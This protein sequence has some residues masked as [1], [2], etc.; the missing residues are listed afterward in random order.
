VS[1]SG[2]EWSEGLRN[3][4]SVIIRRYTHHTQFYCFFHIPLVLLCI[5]V[6]MVVCFVW[7]CL[8][9]YNMYSYCYV[10]FIVMY[11]YCYVLL[12][13]CYVFLLLCMF[14]VF[15][16]IVLFCVLFVC[17]CVLYCCHRVS[18]QLQL[19]KICIIYISWRVKTAVAY[20]WQPYHLHVPTIL[21]SGSL[22]LLEPSRNVQ[23]CNGKALPSL[24]WR[25]IS[26]QRSN[27][28]FHILS[29]FISP[30]CQ[31][32]Y[33]TGRSMATSHQ[34]PCKKKQFCNYGSREVQTHF[35]ALRCSKSCNL[36]FKLFCFLNIENLD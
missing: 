34:L 13:L 4:V 27:S 22:N 32:S 5:T 9:L 6:Y 19:K 23:A 7:F 18:T 14:C 30:V 31:S 29:Q 26:K 20:G 3:R 21:K 10:F 36:R 28:S 2:V 35:P 8:I 15:C 17:K 33:R 24:Y 16:F 1:A 11:S 12:L 25:G